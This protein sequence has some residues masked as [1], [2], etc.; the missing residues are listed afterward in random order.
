MEK[1]IEELLDVTPKEI[2]VPVQLEPIDPEAVDALMNGDG[3]VI[4]E[5][6]E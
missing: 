5:L 3:I 1:K 4:V 6:D 2:R